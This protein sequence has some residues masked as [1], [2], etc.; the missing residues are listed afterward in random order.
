MLDINLFRVEKG[1]NLQLLKDSQIARGHA[2]EF[3]DTVVEKDLT[4]RTAR[5][6]ADAKNKQIN[7][8]QK[9]L[10]MAIKSKSQD[11]TSHLIA[12]KKEL[13]EEKKVLLETAMSQEK[14][15]NK[16][17]MVNQTT[18]TII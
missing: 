5:F 7:L 2:P 3:V 18:I 17:L 1:A 12:Q 6:K 4:W 11:S 13:E 8:L 16:I 15:L 14:E 10:A 9:E